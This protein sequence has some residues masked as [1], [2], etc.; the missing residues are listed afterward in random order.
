MEAPLRGLARGRGV[1]VHIALWA[2]VLA[3]LAVLVV[4][5]V[6]A[7][8]HDWYPPDCCSGRDCRAIRMDDVELQPGGFYV[9]ESREL[10]PY[11]DTRIR[12]TPPEGRNLY[13]RCSQGGEPEGET[14]C[15]Y[16][17]NWTQ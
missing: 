7:R 9:R 14:L 4:R 8:A 11:S 1:K 5:C 16:I 13:H 15:I 10:I 17:P 12:K 6:P 2:F 3:A